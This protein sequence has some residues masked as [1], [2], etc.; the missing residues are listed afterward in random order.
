VVSG[1]PTEE[2]EELES[3]EVST[4]AIEL[5]WVSGESSMSGR[6]QM[7]LEFAIK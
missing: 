7:S 6:N 5:E 1:I 4:D 2:V 3:N